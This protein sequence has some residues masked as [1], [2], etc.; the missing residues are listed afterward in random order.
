M[1]TFAWSPLRALMKM[2]GAEIVSRVTVDKLMDWLEEYAKRITACSIDIAKN[3]FRKKIIYD[4]VRIAIELIGIDVS[5]VAILRGSR[6]RRA[7]STEGTVKQKVPEKKIPAKQKPIGKKKAP[8]KTSAISKGAIISKIA[9]RNTQQ[10]EETRKP[11]TKKAPKK[12]APP[13][14]APP[15]KKDPTTKKEVEDFLEQSKAYIEAENYT[16]A[17]NAAYK[18]AEAAKKLNITDLVKELDQIRKEAI[19]KEKVQTQ[20]VL[21]EFAATQTLKDVIELMDTSDWGIELKNDALKLQDRIE[22]TEDADKREKLENIQTSGYS[23]RNYLLVLAQA[24]NRGDKNF[25][26]VI[27]SF[28]GWMMQGAKVNKRMDYST[29]YS[30]KIMVPVFKKRKTQGSP[31]DSFKIGS[32]F[33]IS[34]TN[35]YEDYLAIK[36]NA[37]E[38]LEYKDEI[39]YEAAVSFVEKNFPD[40]KIDSKEKSS[41]AL[42][43]LL[44]YHIIE[45]EVELKSIENR[46]EKKDE[47][48]AELVAYLLMR[49]HEEKGGYKIKYD[50]GYSNV[51]A[52]NI[53]EAFQFR[54]FERAYNALVKY[55]KNLDV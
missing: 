26:G 21:D 38:A 36:K 18:A 9:K 25:V 42:F 43:H 19:E 20:E 17:K 28:S 5:G 46:T 12:K 22:S 15:K 44:G 41:H 7:K 23:I 30:Y 53:L 52:L 4:D 47:V 48:L 49:R 35:R 8:A 50:F 33:D 27:S 2:A 11:V 6:S 55:V 32:V 54:E 24:R 40:Y 45:S 29:P 31:L 37:R 34:Q 39:S 1:V 3:S 14:K 13:K 51:W 16:D 10:I